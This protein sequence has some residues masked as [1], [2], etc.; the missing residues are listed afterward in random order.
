MSDELQYGV[1]RTLDDPPRILWWDL[2]QAMVVIMITGFGM[3]AG[4]FL[5]GMILGVGVAWLYG[6]LK[7]GKHPAFAVHLAYWH[8]PQGVIAFKKTPPSHHREL[9]G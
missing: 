3:M 2:D 4:Y 1:P 6:K 8:L 9:I 5:G 7:T